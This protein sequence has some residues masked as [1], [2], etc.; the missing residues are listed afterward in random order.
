MRVVFRRIL[1]KNPGE[2]LRKM[3]R[4]ISGKE[5]SREEFLEEF[6]IYFMETFWNEKR[7]ECQKELRYPSKYRT[8]DSC[9][10]AILEEL[11]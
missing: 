6:R 11:R 3:P 1:T 10:R 8:H 4:R 7:G 9:R 5:E 2:N